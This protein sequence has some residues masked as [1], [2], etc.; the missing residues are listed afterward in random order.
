MPV[1]LQAKFLTTRP[2]EGLSCWLSGKNL[3]AIQETRFQSLGREDILEESMATYSRILVEKIP[4]TEE[5]GWLWSLRLQSWTQLKQLHT[6]EIT[7]EV[8]KSKFSFSNLFHLN[9][10]K[11]YFSKDVFITLHPFNKY[12]KHPLC[13]TFP[14]TRNTS[15]ELLNL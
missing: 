9:N 3:P 7:R 10:L 4:W 1:V 2:P 15:S 6:H 11:T 12:L 13:A 8:P 5:P 14:D